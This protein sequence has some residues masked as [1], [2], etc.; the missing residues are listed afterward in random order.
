[1]N[2]KRLFFDFLQKYNALETYKR[3]FKATIKSH[4]IKAQEYTPLGGSFVWA[5]TPE[6]HEY[7]SALNEKWNSHFKSLKK[8]YHF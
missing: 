4:N 3:A 7:W 1:M 2:K 8:R 6:G 5:R